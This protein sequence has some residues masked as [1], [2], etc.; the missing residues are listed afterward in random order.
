MIVVLPHFMFLNSSAHRH[1]GPVARA[2]AVMS[3]EYFIGVEIE[4][5]SEEELRK[6]SATPTM[7]V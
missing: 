5:G 2:N 1:V 3:P 6:Y 4:L 7:G